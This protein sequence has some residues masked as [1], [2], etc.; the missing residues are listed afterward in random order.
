[1]V[2]GANSPHLT[3]ESKSQSRTQVTL[4]QCIQILF[5]IFTLYGFRKEK[6]DED[7]EVKRY[8]QF[9]DEAD[10][11]WMS[12]FKYKTAAFF[13]AWKDEPIPNKPFKSP[14]NPRFLVGGRAARWLH[15]YLRQ[16][17]SEDQGERMKANS[18]L[19]TLLG[20]KRGFP[21]P[22]DEIVKQKTRA[23]FETITQP[24]EPQTGE[25]VH[26][27]GKVEIICRARIEHEIQRTV[28]EIFFRF[29]FA[30]T[31]MTEDEKKTHDAKIMTKAFFPSTSANYIKSRKDAGSVS[32]ILESE[33][34]EHIRRPG[35]YRQVPVE[36]ETRD[37]PSQIYIRQN[38]EGIDFAMREL[39]SVC[40]LQAELEPNIAEPLGL[41]EPLKVRVITKGPPF[42]MYILKFLQKR[43]HRAL[44]Q[45][46]TFALIGNPTG[47]ASTLESYLNETMGLNSRDLGEEEIFISGDYKAATD[48]IHSWA[49]EAAANA[50]AEMLGLD[51]RMTEMFREALT[52]HTIEFTEG[53]VTQQREQTR[54]QLMG[55]I[56]S[57]PILCIIN[58][59]VTRMAFELGESKDC[60]LANCPMAING[61]D[62]VLRTKKSTTLYWRKATQAVGLSESVGKT[63]FSREFL[64]INS[65]NFLCERNRLLPVPFINMGLVH[66]LKRS[67]GH[68]SLYDSDEHTSIGATYRETLESTPPDLKLQV[69][70]LFVHYH[71]RILEKWKLPWH[72]PE[73]LGGFGLTG[74]KDPSEL[75]LR[76]AHM[77]ILNWKT[78]KPNP[79]GTNWTAWKVFEHA[80]ERLPK[81]FHTRDPMDKG[82]KAF[83][84]AVQKEAL[85]LLLDSNVQ[86]GDLLKTR[87]KNM[88]KY[89]RRKLRR[90][91][92]LWGLKN[93]KKLPAPL[94]ADRLKFQKLYETVTGYKGTNTHIQLDTEEDLAKLDEGLSSGSSKAPNFPYS[95]EKGRW[96]DYSDPEESNDSDVEEGWEIAYRE[97]LGT[98]DRA[99]HGLEERFS[100]RE[101]RDEEKKVPLST[102]SNT[103]TWGTP[104]PLTL[105]AV[106]QSLTIPPA[107]FE[108]PSRTKRAKPVKVQN[109]LN[110]KALKQKLG[111]E[112]YKNLLKQR[113][114]NMWSDYNEQYRF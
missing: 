49:S 98:Q 6:G 28:R 100:D 111:K 70:Y 60:S 55:S 33:H 45:L 41:A 14:D 11:D 19:L 20:A 68:V 29:H 12:V 25:L 62:V 107:P 37:T 51:P 67:G 88:Q 92:V 66:G 93:Y 35:G 69:H 21:K 113:E 104:Q 94:E 36:E 24:Q 30:R 15:I 65:R 42:R 59:A 32:A 96:A 86:L 57:F 77:L 39:W 74:L 54:G 105:E 52:G 17:K 22:G 56:V 53:G 3:E 58:A 75:D 5:E 97:R 82:I 7:K 109:Y 27:E 43:L 84:S 87:D 8:Q 1:M 16:L 48:N 38:T 80:K 47:Y 31:K 61:D 101:S 108:V 4:P 50:I 89:I 10:G 26:A 114:D 90:N 76:I 13:S 46:Q 18:L 106:P 81:P 91:E 102:A 9:I 72:I 23:F 110:E 44:R 73:W 2:A 99:N 95:K 79:I 71:K 112:G 103:G 63:Y 64:Q 78:M 83:E 85:N 40:R 34:V